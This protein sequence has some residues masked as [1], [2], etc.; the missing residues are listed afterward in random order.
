[1]VRKKTKRSEKK[2]RSKKTV[3]QEKAASDSKNVVRINK[4][5]LIGLGVL[6]VALIAWFLLSPIKGGSP[7]TTPSDQKSYFDMYVMSQ[8]PYGAQAEDEAIKAIKKFNGVVGLNIYYIVDSQGTGFGSLHG[9]PEVDEN[10]RQL[11]IK[12]LY[13]KLFYDYLLCFNENYA[14]GQTQ[15]VSCANKLGIDTKKDADYADKKGA[16][17]LRASEAQSKKVGASG[18][19][20]IYLDGAPYQSGRSE[21]DFARAV[22]DKYNY[23]L[24]GCTGIP[25][26]VVFEVIIVSDQN[27]PSCDTSRIRSVTKQLFPGATFKT[28]QFDSAE[29]KQLVQANSLE[30]LPAYLFDEKVVETNTWKTNPQITSSFEKLDTGY[31][32]LDQASGATWFVDENKRKEYQQLMTTY[33]KRNLEALGYTSDKPRLDYFVM[34]FCPYGN[35]ADEAASQVYSLLGDSVVI[36]PHYIMG[37][38]NGQLNALHGVQEANQNVRE[39]CVLKE[40]GMQKFFDFTLKSN[41]LCTSANADSCWESAATQSGVDAAKVKACE[42]S[43][44]LAIAQQE[45]DLINSLVSLYNGQLVSPSASPTFL[46]NGETYSGGRDGE[47]LKNALCAK[48]TGELPAECSQ[49]ITAQVAAP[50]GNC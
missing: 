34:S 45:S 20:T 11:C 28:V 1:M 13:P 36:V 23:E 32:L 9:Q 41:Q 33:P 44:K 18:S 21:L 2:T 50:Q 40:F 37:V 4:H 3:H 48:F 17:L 10:I 27:C 22:C 38:S 42:S 15:Y 19:P 16:E 35:P 26:P 14:A 25:K 5:L 46:I 7:T 43:Q 12:E 29:G 24:E 6:A 47:S 30:Y 39:L 49:V 8:C 31:K